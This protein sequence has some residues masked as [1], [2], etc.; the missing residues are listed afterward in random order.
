[1]STTK[2]KNAQSIPV[3][4]SLPDNRFQVSRIQGAR[5]QFNP[6][7][8]IQQVRE[9]YSSSSNVQNSSKTARYAKAIWD[10]SA[11]V[12]KYVTV[13]T[14]GYIA[15][16]GASMFAESFTKMQGT[17]H[18]L[19]NADLSNIGTVVMVGTGVV[20]LAAAKRIYFPKNKGPKQ[21]A[22]GFW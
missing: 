17:A 9:K 16:T 22:K 8:Q 14:A 18:T 11:K 5:M 10:T 20:V 12:V 15:L 19:S 21:K 13:G 3:T 7:S 4:S 6:T 2:G 1:M